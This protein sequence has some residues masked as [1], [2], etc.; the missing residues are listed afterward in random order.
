MV[1]MLLGT[2]VGA[3]FLGL[4]VLVK[5]ARRQLTRVAAAS[6]VFTRQGVN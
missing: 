6:R 1:T 3:M 2:A 4:V 5:R